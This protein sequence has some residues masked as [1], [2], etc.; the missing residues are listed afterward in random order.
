[1]LLFSVAFAR[2][3]YAPHK[4]S[5]VFATV[6]FSFFYMKLRGRRAFRGLDPYAKRRILS[7]PF[8]RSTLEDNLFDPASCCPR[9][10]HCDAT[11]ICL[12]PRVLRGG[13]L[14]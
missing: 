2:M 5:G 7:R 3:V 4:Q 8:A 11:V 14:V 6:A 9:Y 1:M 10:F 12:P 13:G